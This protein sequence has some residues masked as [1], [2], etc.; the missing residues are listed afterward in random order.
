VCGPRRLL[1]PQAFPPPFQAIS[2]FP[3]D[4]L[5]GIADRVGIKLYTMHWPM[6][7][8]Y[9]ARD[10]IGGDA[11]AAALDALTAAVARRLGLTDRLV[12]GAGL[13]YPE[14]QQPHPAGALAQ[15]AK[16]RTAQALAGRVPVTAFV[17]SY[18]PTADFIARY[19]LAAATGLPLWINRYGYLSEAKLAALA[20]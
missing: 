19:R 11:P 17:H 4:A 15:A 12:D 7:A 5:E 14:P 6:L 1:E 18:G 10:L 8:R 20:G 16:L 9:W 13:V 3:L 2:G